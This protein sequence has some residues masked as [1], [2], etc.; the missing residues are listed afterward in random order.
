MSLQQDS[1]RGLNKLAKGQARAIL[2]LIF[3]S[4]LENPVSSN[5]AHTKDELLGTDELF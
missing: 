2:S 4:R 5:V 3:F 1:L